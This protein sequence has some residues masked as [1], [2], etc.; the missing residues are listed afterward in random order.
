MASKHMVVCYQCGKRFDTASITGLGTGYDADKRRYMCPSCMR[1][2]NRVSKN[3]IKEAK[4]NQRA[5]ENYGVKTPGWFG[6]NWALCLACFGLFAVIGMFANGEAEAFYFYLVWTIVFGLIWYFPYKSRKK[7]IALAKYQYELQ[8]YEQRREA[9]LR[10]KLLEEQATEIR[11]RNAQ[12][13]AKKKAEAEKKA[14]ALIICPFC[15]AHT[16]N[17]PVCEY[18]GSLLKER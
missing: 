7:E 18:C 10:A 4:A 5:A 14:N 6:R 16:K 15:G 17:E 8:I 9:D 1:K 11:N 12:E 2:Q 3:E 13:E